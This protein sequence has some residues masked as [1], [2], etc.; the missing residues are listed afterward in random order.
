MNKPS[1]FMCLILKMLQLQPEKDIV[2]E[3]IK[4]EDFKYVRILGAFY[5]RLVGKPV[6]I[7]KY[8]ELLYNDFRKVRHR[9]NAGWEVIRMDEFIDQLLTSDYACDIALP[10][11]PKRWTLEEAKMLEPRLSLADM[12]DESEEEEEDE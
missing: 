10:H 8:L 2:I 7:Y 4:N 12:D 1:K 6:D 5:L 3:F 9:T 11:L